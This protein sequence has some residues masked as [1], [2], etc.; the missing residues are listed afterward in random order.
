MAPLVT[1]SAK[2]ELWTFSRHGALWQCVMTEKY[3]DVWLVEVICKGRLA[4]WYQAP[5]E[6]FALAWAEALRGQF[7]DVDPDVTADRR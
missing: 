1:S 6:P 4:S 7:E 5:S 2:R 3:A